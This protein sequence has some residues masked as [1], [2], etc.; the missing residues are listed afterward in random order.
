M[1][2]KERSLVSGSLSEERRTQ[3]ELVCGPM[4][5]ART[6][7]PWVYTDPAFHAAEEQFVL[8][9]EWLSVGRADELPEP[10]D[11]FTTQVLND[12]LIVVRGAD[13]EIRTLSAVCRHRSALV[14]SGRGNANKFL[15]PYHAWAYDTSG[16]L[17]GAPMM[18][19]NTEFDKKKCSLPTVRTEIW[20]GWIF[21]NLDPDA[22]PLGPRL[23]ELDAI[24]EPYGIEN[25]RSAGP[26]LAFDQHY[27]WKLITDNWENFHIIGTH[28][29]SLLPI[30]A[31]TPHTEY[32][33]KD[34][35]AFGTWFS[36]FQAE[37]PHDIPPIPDFPAERNGV[38][39]VHVFPCHLL[40][41]SA[42]ELIYFKV[43]PRS[44]DLFRLEVEVLVRD[45]IV[46]DP[47]YQ[48]VLAGRLKS[49]EFIHGE[50][51]VPVLEGC[52]AG[53]QSR[54][55]QQGYRVSPLKVYLLASTGLV[56]LFAWGFNSFGQAFFIM[57][58]FH[59]LQYFGI[60]WAFEQKNMTRL[61]GVQGMRFAKPIALVLFIAPAFAYG[62]WVEF[63]DAGIEWLWG[64]TLVVSIMHFWYDGFVWSVRK[65][66]V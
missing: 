46:K 54:L 29:T 12:P 52:H 16:R 47:A 53:V 2:S 59:A 3:L 17:V 62:L 1:S 25:L 13:G 23:A 56:S 28:K 4:E 30:P 35:A 8:R 36:R 41:V 45:E 24:L 60:V 37:S 51:D 5:Q 38:V 33:W 19:G 6:L 57:N 21:V 66:Q 42:T 26:P 63:L 18:E 7:P 58:F 22:E 65:K 43:L 20:Q 31:Y 14:A 48:E 39:G 50:E 10:G 64:I 61:F 27:N 40:L 32:P 9:R 44:V 34:Q 15:C 11:Y 55:A 49:L